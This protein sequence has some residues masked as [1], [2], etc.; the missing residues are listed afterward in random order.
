M[1]TPYGNQTADMRF[2]FEIVA[3][4]TSATSGIDYA[5][6]P[7]EAVPGDN[8]GLKTVGAAVQGAPA[9]QVQHPSAP[10]IASAG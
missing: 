5:A 9:P 6:A 8:F 2:R 7:S 1:W 10:G 3:H 4:D